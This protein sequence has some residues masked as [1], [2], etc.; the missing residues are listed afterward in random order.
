MT[1]EEDKDHKYLSFHERQQIVTM[2]EQKKR[3]LEE[4]NR[5]FAELGIETPAAETAT[6]AEPKGAS[7]N[8]LHV[9]ACNCILM[10]GN[11]SFQSLHSK[12]GQFDAFTMVIR[13]SGGVYSRRHCSGGMITSWFESGEDSAEDGAVDFA[14]SKKKKK[15]D[16]EKKAT[17]SS[18]TATPAP[19]TIV[20]SEEEEPSVIDPAEV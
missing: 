14:A 19:P 18:E 10:L 5:V 9:I 16:K 17:A 12:L 7:R 8:E 1:L 15:K 4:M 20:D 3:E 13:P 6:K 2:Q 11:S